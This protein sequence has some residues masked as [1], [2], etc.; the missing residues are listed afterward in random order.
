MDELKLNCFLFA[1]YLH[2]APCRLYFITS[3]AE[4]GQGSFKFQVCELMLWL[5]WTL[6]D[7]SR[8]HPVLHTLNA[9]LQSLHKLK[10]FGPQTR[11]TTQMEKNDNKSGWMRFPVFERDHPFSSWK[12][13]NCMTLQCILVLN[14]NQWI[15]L[16]SY[17]TR[18][19]FEQQ[20]DYISLEAHYYLNF[21][22]ISCRF[23][24]RCSSTLF[25]KVKVW[26]H[27][28]SKTYSE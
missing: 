23:I 28:M 16:F 6:R 17:W 27:Y 12:I 21:A 26:T 8:A 1:V 18:I 15:V 5:G 10:Q 4:E 24:L 25:G 20:I 13:R 3:K 2:R 14:T 11:S 7:E 22:K 9:L 19:Q